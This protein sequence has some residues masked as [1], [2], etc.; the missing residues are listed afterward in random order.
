MM[1]LLEIVGLHLKSEQGTIVRD[2]DLS[3]SAGQC[4]ALIGESGSGKSMTSLSIGDMLP[5]TVWVESGKIEWCGSSLLAMS[6]TN[7]E[8]LR[9]KE[10]AYVFQDYASVLTPFITI[11][12]QLD[13]TLKAH[14]ML[15]RKNRKERIEQVLEHVQLPKEIYNR[16]PFQL[17]GGQLQRVSLAVVI[18]LE[19]KLLILDEPTTALD[20]TNAN[21]ILRIISELKERT[22]CGI[23]FISHNLRNVKRYA[24]Q[25]TVMREGQV[26]ET[27]STLPLL[28]NPKQS[29]TRRLIEAIPSLHPSTEMV[30]ESI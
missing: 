22:R 27:G 20:Q 18:M 7:R 9:G 28:N 21:E 11:G 29:Y 5:A 26:I 16:Y 2:L 30:H 3:V 6:K 4:H 15:V 25:V 10:I 19:P 13:E 8:R 14:H 23:L 12:K 1:N 17:S 24:D